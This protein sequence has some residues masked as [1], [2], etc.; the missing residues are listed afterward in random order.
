MST[1][2]SSRTR[3]LAEL[4]LRAYWRYYLVGT[5]WATCIWTCSTVMAK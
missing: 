4:Y 5:V 1:L 2:T 3:L